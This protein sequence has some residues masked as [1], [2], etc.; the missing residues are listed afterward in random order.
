VIADG[1][2]HPEEST[3]FANAISRNPAR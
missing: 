2:L 3:Q 1:E